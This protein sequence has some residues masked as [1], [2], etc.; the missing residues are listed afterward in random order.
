M[1]VDV[2]VHIEFCKSTFRKN[3][4]GCVLGG[5]YLAHIHSVVYRHCPCAYP[6]MD[7]YIIL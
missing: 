1:M 6:I 3:W 2:Y 4:T 7:I 5:I